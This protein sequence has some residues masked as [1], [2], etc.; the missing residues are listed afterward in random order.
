MNTQFIAYGVFIDDD[1]HSVE[2]VT[3]GRDYV[4]SVIALGIA[5]KATLVG[6]YSPNDS[7]VIYTERDAKCHS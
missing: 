2:C 7:H 1:Y 6:W 4:D 5:E 3:D